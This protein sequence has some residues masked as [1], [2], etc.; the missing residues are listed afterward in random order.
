MR[1]GGWPAVRTRP[2]SAREVGWRPL[3][4]AWFAVSVG[5]PVA[6]IVVGLLGFATLSAPAALGLGLGRRAEEFLVDMLNFLLLSPVLTWA[7]LLPGA[8][9]ALVAARLGWAGWLVALALGA[10]AGALLQV[11]PTPL[12][13]ADRWSWPAVLTAALVAGA[14]WLG[15]RLDRPDL[16]GRD[17]RCRSGWPGA[18]KRLAPTATVPGPTSRRRALRPEGTR[19]PARW[20]SWPPPRP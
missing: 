9:L 7:F 20:R 8:L 17:P 14:F 2:V 18:R 16:F 1:R 11:A 13:D 12:W 19:A 4:V 3:V 5:V 6:T 15:V 10:A